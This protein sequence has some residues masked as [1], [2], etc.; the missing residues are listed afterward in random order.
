MRQADCQFFELLRKGKTAGWAKARAPQ[1]FPAE[2]AR[3]VPTR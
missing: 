3:A 2:K 1:V